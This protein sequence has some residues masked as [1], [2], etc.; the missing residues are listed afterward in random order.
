MPP[1]KLS[2]FTPLPT[3]PSVEQ[4]SATYY[5]RLSRFVA[6][7]GLQGVPVAQE[8]SGSG[9]GGQRREHVE[10]EDAE[11]EEEE[12]GEVQ[13]GEDTDMETLSGRESE[14][15]PEPTPPSP[16]EETIPAPSDNTEAQED[17]GETSRPT[18]R[19]ILR[20]RGNTIAATT[21]APQPAYTAATTRRGEVEATATHPTTSPSPAQPNPVRRSKRA[22]TKSNQDVGTNRDEEE[23]AGSVATGYLSSRPGP[24][25]N[26]TIPVLTLKRCSPAPEQPQQQ[27]EERSGNGKAKEKGKQPRQN[28]N[29]NTRSQA[30]DQPPPPPLLRMSQ[31]PV[32]EWEPIAFPNEH[33]PAGMSDPRAAW[34]RLFP[35]QDFHPEWRE[36]MLWTEGQWRVRTAAEPYVRLVL[37]WQGRAMARRAVA[38]EKWAQARADAVVKV[39][40]ARSL[41]GMRGAE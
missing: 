34:T 28:H 3:T 33:S 21:A 25:L 10:G 19:L 37:G 17:V 6:D 41:M 32:E 29:R 20:L 9:S 36:R 40:A 13:G 39:G 35:G 1:R 8:A 30:A 23:A 31:Q 24:L 4:L 5:A 7:A 26:Q 14:L 12:E 27:Q 2:G 15:E 22:K 18:P 16:S 11:Q 38:A